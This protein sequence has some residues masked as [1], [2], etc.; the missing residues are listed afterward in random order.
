M[1]CWYRGTELTVLSLHWRKLHSEASCLKAKSQALLDTESAGNLMDF[2]ASGTVRNKYVV[3]KLVPFI[4][5]CYS[6]LMD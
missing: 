3:Y 1:R 2:P 5:F 6:H 4:V